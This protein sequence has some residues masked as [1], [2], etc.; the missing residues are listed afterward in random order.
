MVPGRARAVGIGPVLEGKT[1]RMRQLFLRQLFEQHRTLRNDHISQTSLTIRFE[2][3]SQKPV[4]SP[5]PCCL[6]KRVRLPAPGL[7]RVPFDA[8]SSCVGEI[9]EVPRP[10]KAKKCQTYQ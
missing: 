3:L 5:G 6:Q 7:I 10:E 9:V 4:V 2:Y 1:V 8:E